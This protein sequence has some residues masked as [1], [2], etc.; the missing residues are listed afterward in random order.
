MGIV[1]EAYYRGVPLLGVPGITLDFALEKI[2][3]FPMG[4]LAKRRSSAFGLPFAVHDR[5]TREVQLKK[6]TPMIRSWWKSSS[7]YG[8]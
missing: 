4:I 7:L 6:V 2:V 1:W 8:C 3:P 5:Q